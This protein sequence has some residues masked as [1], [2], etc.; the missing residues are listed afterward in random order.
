MARN[1]WMAAMGGALLW[2]VAAQPAQADSMS[3]STANGWDVSAGLYG[4][5]IWLDGDVKLRN[6]DFAVSADPIDFIEAFRG[7]VMGN[8]EARKGK[9]ALY[10]DIFYVDLHF[11][12]SVYGSANPFGN[13][14]IG[15]RA[16][17]ELDLDFGLYQAGALYQVAETETAYG[18]TRLEIGSGARWVRENPDLKARIDASATSDFFDIKRHYAVASDRVIEWVDALVVSRVTQELSEGKAVVLMGDA[19][20]FS[21]DDFSWQVSAMY[22]V[23]GTL[24]GFDSTTM[25]GYRALGLK[26]E[27]EGENGARGVD[28]VMQGP[29]AE[30][31][32]RW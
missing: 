7:G 1:G 18:A 17:A 22:Q 30:V 11:D 24:F 28:T 9:L 20:G 4:W 21:E 25:L 8:F 12:N 27:D 31:A 23:D 26:F 5:A 6:E 15:G 10:A 13:L 19:G 14:I 2:L 16:K 32:F 29:V 3:A